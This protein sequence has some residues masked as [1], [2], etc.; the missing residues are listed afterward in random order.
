MNDDAREIAQAAMAAAFLLSISVL[1]IEVGGYAD[2][3]RVS[4]EFVQG[5]GPAPRVAKLRRI[6]GEIAMCETQVGAAVERHEVDLD[7][8]RAAVLRRF[9]AGGV[10]PT[11]DDVAG[12]HE[13]E[14]RSVGLVFAAVE[15][16][17]TNP[18]GAAHTSVDL[19]PNDRN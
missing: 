6:A 17:K 10:L 18:I 13:L 11:H 7:A 19:D 16:A 2:V 12:R 8:R 1:R 14:E 4:N 9:A 3:F 15:R 5:A